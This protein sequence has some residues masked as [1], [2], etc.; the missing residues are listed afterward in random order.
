MCDD[1]NK[2][3]EEYQEDLKIREMKLKIPVKFESD[4]EIDEMLDELNEKKI[5]L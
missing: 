4:E 5:N 3:F 1:I 2:E